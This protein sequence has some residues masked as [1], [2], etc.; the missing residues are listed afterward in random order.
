MANDDLERRASEEIVP[1]T[2]SRGWELLGVAL[3]WGI[4]GTLAGCLVAVALAMNMSLSSEAPYDLAI[5]GG[6]IGVIAGICLELSGG[7]KVPS[8]YP[9]SER[10]TSENSEFDDSGPPSSTED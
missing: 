4:P 7:E 3:A 2:P 1:F 9:P 8:T 5:T 10:A 6:L